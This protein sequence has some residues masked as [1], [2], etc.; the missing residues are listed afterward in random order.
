MSLNKQSWVVATITTFIMMLAALVGIPTAS[1]VPG[2]PII[3]LTPSCTVTLV[4]GD[5]ATAPLAPTCYDPSGNDQD[6]LLV[7]SEAVSGVS[8]VGADMNPYWYDRPNSTNGASQVSVQSMYY[9]TTQGMF[10]KGHAWRLDF[11]TAV[12]A[13]PTANSYWVELGSCVNSSTTA[14]RVTAFF[15][16]EVGTD[17]RYLTNV[18]PEAS[19]NN[20][21]VDVFD[22]EPASRVY[23]GATVGVPLITY[24][25]RQPG[26]TPGYTYQVKFWV[27]YTGDVFSSETR[28]L[29]ATQSV[30]VPKCGKG[31]EPVVGSAARPKAVITVLNKG[32]VFSRVKVAL[33]GKQATRATYRVIRDPKHGRTIRKTYT[34]RHKVLRYD[35]VRKGT[36]VKVRFGGKVVR[37]RI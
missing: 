18:Y 11:N 17:G 21:G 6:E 24:K 20:G 9:D 3:P 13:V 8:Y 34:T 14:R 31:S 26:L 16:N 32:R 22:T 2:D 36:V 1:A 29:G 37:K 4:S 30:Y 25:D 35:R 15:K 10:V 33:G 5:A 23:D 19:A 12:T 28:Q 27:S 7:P